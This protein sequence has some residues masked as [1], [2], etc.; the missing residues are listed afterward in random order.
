LRTASD[1]AEVDRKTARRYV[2]AAVAAGLTRKGA[3]GQLSDKLLGAVGAA[4]RAARPGGHG[5]AWDALAA[6]EMRI[7]DYVNAGLHTQL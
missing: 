5:Q 7:R 6:E 3:Q 2:E 1:R 4:V